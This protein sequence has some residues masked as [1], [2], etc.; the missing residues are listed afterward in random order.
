M[1]YYV[2]ALSNDKAEVCIKRAV[3]DNDKAAAD[4][5]AERWRAEGH[6]IRRWSEA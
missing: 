2:A 5:L 3:I 6:K 1:T 4:W